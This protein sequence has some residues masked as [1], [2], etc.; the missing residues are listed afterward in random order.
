MELTPLA[1]RIAIPDEGRPERTQEEDRVK[2]MFRMRPERN[3]SVAK[4]GEC[5]R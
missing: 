1:K 3:R 2:R 5:M 4:G